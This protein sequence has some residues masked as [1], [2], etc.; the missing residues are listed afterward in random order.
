MG[1]FIQGSVIVIFYGIFLSTQQHYSLFLVLFIIFLGSFIGD[2]IGFYLGRKLGSKKVHKLGLKPSS[3]IYKASCG[4]FKKFGVF[5]IILGRQFNLTR[6]FIPFFAGLSKMNYYSF[7]FF[8]FVSGVLWTLITFMLGYYFGYVA[9]EKFEFVFA[10]ILFCLFYF[11]ILYFIYGFFKS[12]YSEHVVIIKRYAFLNIF[13][14]FILFILFAL[15]LGFKETGIAIYLNEYLSFLIID[16][17]V[18]FFLFSKLFLLLF[19]E[20]IFLIPLILKKIKVFLIFFWSTFLYLQYVFLNMLLVKKFFDVKLSFTFF[21]ITLGFFFI[22]ILIYDSNYSFKLKKY[23]VSITMFCLVFFILIYSSFLDG[24][25]YSVILTFLS[26]SIGC[27]LLYVLSH[28]K[29]LDS[30][31][32]NSIKKG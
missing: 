21:M 22:L 11:G 16:F 19:F 23:L 18:N 3:P 2:L 12:F 6:A 32:S 28:Y 25:F 10:F 15:F 9:L 7:V 24:N 5:S 14:I 20:A 29:V 30:Y 4:F 8:A 13:A 1:S 27:E 26:A 17:G 31:L